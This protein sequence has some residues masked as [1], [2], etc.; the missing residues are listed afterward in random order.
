MINALVY[1]H[2]YVYFLICLSNRNHLPTH[3]TM[4]SML[5]CVVMMMLQYNTFTFKNIY[6]EEEP[7]WSGH[8]MHLPR[9]IICQ[10][11]RCTT[12]DFYLII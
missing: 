4:Q 3:L 5:S 6:M 12:A 10:T 2:I 9:Y 1:A 8:I 11:T 7:R